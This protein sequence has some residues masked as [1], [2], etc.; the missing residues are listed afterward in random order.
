M[1]K[2]FLFALVMALLITS[3]GQ[4]QKGSNTLIRPVKTAKVISNSVIRKDLSVLVVGV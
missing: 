1:K 4:K 2:M 3:C